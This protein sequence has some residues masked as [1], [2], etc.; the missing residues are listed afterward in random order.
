MTAIGTPQ[1]VTQEI[2]ELCQRLNPTAR[3]VF[4]RITPEPNCEPDDCFASVRRKVD[5]EGGRIQFG[6]AIWEWP[7]VFIEAEHH[8]VYEPPRGRP[9]VDISP[10]DRPDVSRRLFLPDDTAAYDFDNEGNRRDNLREALVDDP[11][12]RELFRLAGERNAI[13]NTIP[14]LGMITVEGDVAERFQQNLEQAVMVELHLGMKYTPQN[15]PC[16][17]GSGRRFKRCHGL[18]LRADRVI[19]RA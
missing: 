15:A 5:V 14:G 7:R 8:A 3:P 2:M 4:L 11:L 17:C 6:W 1:F 10:S 19:D 9:W 18:P 12:V 13:I 16:F